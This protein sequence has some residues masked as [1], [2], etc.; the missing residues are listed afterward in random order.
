LDVGCASGSQRPDWLHALIAD[1]AQEAVGLDH[2][3]ERVSSIKERGYEI[4]LGDAQDFD[5]GRRFDVVF[6]GELIEHLSCFSGFLSSARRHLDLDG[7]LVLTTPNAFGVN[8]F[9]YRLGGDP[10][11]NEDHTCWFCE[12]TIAQLLRRH[13]FDVISVRYLPHRSEGIRQLASTAIRL[14]LPDRLKWPD[15]LVV[16]RPV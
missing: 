9:I 8:N 15:M 6:A 2:D 4:V 11:V 13:E 7:L 14:P 16:A 12:K 5:L 1:A 10:W 3:E